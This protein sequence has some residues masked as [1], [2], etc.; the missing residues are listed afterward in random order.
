MTRARQRRLL[1]AGVLGAY[2]IV[3]VTVAFTA[4][5]LASV[6]LAQGSGLVFVS[7]DCVLT[8]A[9]IWPGV[10]LLEKADVAWQRAARSSSAKP[11]AP[12]H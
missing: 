9:A 4:A 7:V 6:V 1:L 8:L 11:P 10:V 5:A 12:S 2:T 3:A